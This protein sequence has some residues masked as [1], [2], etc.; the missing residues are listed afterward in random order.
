MTPRSHAE[1]TKPARA[2]RAD[3]TGRRAAWAR[4]LGVPGPAH[5]KWT[6]SSSVPSCACCAPQAPVAGQAEFLDARLSGL[7]LARALRARQRVVGTALRTA[8]TP[9]CTPRL[10]TQPV[11]WPR[12]HDCRLHRPNRPID[13]PDVP[14]S[15]LPLGRAASS[16]E[17]STARRTPLQEGAVGA[18]LCPSVAEGDASRSC[19]PLGSTA[20]MSATT[21][22]DGLVY[23]PTASGKS[24]LS[25]YDHRGRNARKSCWA[26][27]VLPPD[28]Y[29]IFDQAD[30]NDQFDLRGHY[31]GVRSS[32]GAVLG[33]RGERLAKFPHNGVS[34]VPW[35]GFPVSPASGRDSEAPSDHL[36][37]TLIATGTMSR[38]FGRKLQK[39]KA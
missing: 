16:A 32:E 5:A 1:L 34:V 22:P 31:W 36:V 18:T 3:Q 15:P 27:D 25:M 33:T 28:E 37:E 11:L 4:E 7:L 35:H 20:A 19:A 17:V 26:T 8:P 39:R 12:A 38:T 23:G 10:S 9:T 30:T 2:R 24:Y 14:R 21:H 6:D 13:E 29:A